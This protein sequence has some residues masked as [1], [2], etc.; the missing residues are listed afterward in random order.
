MSGSPKVDVVG[1]GLNA[2]DTLIPVQHYHLD[3]HWTH[4]PRACPH[5]DTAPAPAPSAPTGARSAG[6]PVV[7]DLDELS[8]GVDAL[9]PRIDSLTT[10][11]DIPG[12]ISSESD[13]RKSLPA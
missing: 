13:L 8:P 6:I 2:T 11:R 9:L 7:A 12:R 3:G 10:S 1:V 5:V 4:K